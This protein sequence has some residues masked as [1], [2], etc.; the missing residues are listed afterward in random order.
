MSSRRVNNNSNRPYDEDNDEDG[1]IDNDAAEEIDYGHVSNPKDEDNEGRYYEAGPS[2]PSDPL[3]FLP[4]PVAGA[5]EYA[6]AEVAAPLP[7]D[8]VSSTENYPYYDDGS[9]RPNEDPRAAERRIDRASLAMGI[10]RKGVYQLMY[11]QPGEC[12][13]QWFA[14]KA[15]SDVGREKAEELHSNRIDPSHALYDAG[16]QQ[17]WATDKAARKAFNDQRRTEAL[18]HR[19]RYDALQGRPRVAT[20]DAAEDSGDE[21]FAPRQWD[22]TTAPTLGPYRQYPPAGFPALGYMPQPGQFPA[23]IRTNPPSD[24]C[25]A[26]IISKKGTC[27]LGKRGWYPCS[28]CVEKGIV[29]Q[30]VNDKGRVTNAEKERPP[31]WE[32][33]VQSGI[34][35]NAG[36]PPSRRRAPRSSSLDLGAGPSTAAPSSNRRRRPVALPEVTQQTNVNDPEVSDEDVDSEQD[37]ESEGTVRRR[38]LRRTARRTARREARTEIQQNPTPQP[39]PPAPTSRRPG[40]LRN[41]NAPGAA[42]LVIKELGYQPNPGEYP[43]GIRTNPHSDKCQ[44]CQIRKKGD[45]NLGTSGY[46]CSSCVRAGVPDQCVNAAGYRYNMPGRT[47]KG[48]SNVKNQQNRTA[49]Y[50]EVS[51]ALPQS[52]PRPPPVPKRRP[53]PVPER[54]PQPVPERRPQPVPRREPQLVPKRGRPK[55]QPPS[56]LILPMQRTRSM[57]PVIKRSRRRT[58][59]NCIA[60]AVLCTGD[61]GACVSSIECYLDEHKAN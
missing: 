12:E 58:C 17:F 48:G 42:D 41:W 35:S 49:K 23:G 31:G 7:G 32:P 9:A 34:P 53:Q 30:C 16:Y 47:L 50:N 19:R 37:Y 29:D 44:R 1:N 36:V 13:L 51:Q 11:R 5:T 24:R 38:R 39:L 3:A 18:N 25:E 43:L 52:N 10:Q 6:P 28:P 54:R 22:G 20:P 15:R 40:A 27:D 60:N 8:T 26:C 33:P 57:S 55:V 21:R 46:P 2:G 61:A 4:P 59:Q 14:R 45:C 56:R